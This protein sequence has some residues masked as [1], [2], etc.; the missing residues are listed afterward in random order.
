LVNL[1]RR[2]KTAIVLAAD[3]FAFAFGLYLSLA[4]RYVAVDVPFNDRLTWVYVML[5]IAGVATF[6]LSGLYRY[7]IRSMSA[8]VIVL[9]AVGVLGTDAL[10]VLSTYL[11]THILLPRSVPF[12][13]PLVVF[14]L[15]GGTR[16][17]LRAVYLALL[18]FG[19]N[20]ERALIYGAGLVGTQLAMALKNTSEYRILGFLDDDPVLQR[21]RQAGLR[22]YPPS[23]LDEIAEQRAIDTLL[24]SSRSIINGRQSVLMKASGTLGMRVKIA[25]SILDFL[26]DDT[27]ADAMP[28]LRLEDLLGRQ[29]VNPIPDLIGKNIEGQTIL[30]TGAAGSIGSE[31]CR[32]VLDAKPACLIAFEVSEYGLYTLD[33]EL[34]PR[35]PEG[36]ELLCC[37]GSVQDRARIRQLMR[38]RDVTVVYHAAAYKHVPLVEANALAGVAN[39]VFGT[40]VVAEEAVAAPSVRHFV[41]VSTDK[42]VRP[43]NVMGASK[44]MAE[45]VIQNL[46]EQQ[47]ARVKDGKEDTTTLS[48]VRFGNVLGSSGSVVPLFRR[49][50]EEGGPVTVTDRNVTRYFMTI[51][52]AAELVLQAGFL[53]KGG[54]VFVLDMGQ[55]VKLMNLAVMMI[56]L[57]G[58]SVRNPEDPLST[59]ESANGD[60]GNWQGRSNLALSSNSIEIREVGLRPGEKLYEELLIGRDVSKTIHSKIMMATE[61]R[62]ERDELHALLK[63]L[64]EAIDA[65]DEAK[66]VELLREPT[67]LNRNVLS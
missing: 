51:S 30:V 19:E 29:P 35:L 31:I 62:L 21:T 38:S 9:C 67:E 37:L 45:L 33:Q 47:T 4:I 48:L 26:S 11:D 66:T 58:R 8:R 7:L 13:Y 18:P 65:G 12:I 6:W 64:R 60:A 34:R 25:P 54:E 14:V 2:V 49:Q 27:A 50:I 17:F 32:Q 24:V 20:Q 40:Q 46:G 22:V 53:A 15:V 16:L 52:E 57:S 23:K 61:S 55:P 44:R 5:P 10:L 39:N 42:A 43:T 36:C 59:S 41:L 56:Q 3:A 63:G 28:P 1:D